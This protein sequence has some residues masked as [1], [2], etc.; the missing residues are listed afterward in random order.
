MG[1]GSLNWVH[2]SISARAVGAAALP[3]LLALAGCGECP[4]A[5]PDSCPTVDEHLSELN[6]Y[7]VVRLRSDSSAMVQSSTVEV[8]PVAVTDG[9]IAFR[10]DAPD[11][12]PTAESP[13]VHQLGGLRFVLSDFTLG[14]RHVEG[15]TYGIE[16]PHELLLTDRGVELPEL[17]PCSACG[18][19]DGD[20]RASQRP[21]P[22][23][24]LLD[25]DTDAE[26][27]LANGLFEAV[28][29]LDGSSSLLAGASVGAD[30][31]T[32]TTALDANGAAPWL[33][34]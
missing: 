7:T 20:V 11:C 24:L 33:Y 5:G 18:T 34:P 28:F 31:L 1:S 3:L 4:A 21:T 27:L 32:I 25:V 23:A 12:V 8:G 29:E 9:F 2:T 22:D 6:G 13:C 16:G 26:S 30:R 14:Q 15:L 17:T 10:L 19:I